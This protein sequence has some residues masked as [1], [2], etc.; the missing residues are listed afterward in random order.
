MS[1]TLSK[2]EE[3]GFIIEIE[4]V[5]DHFLELPSRQQQGTFVHSARK[6]HSGKIG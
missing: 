1:P 6:T 3:V 5:V 4:G 2:I